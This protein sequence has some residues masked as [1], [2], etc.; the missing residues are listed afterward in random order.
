V[1][2]LALAV[3]HSASGQDWQIQGRLGAGKTHL[4]KGLARRLSDEGL[5]PILVSPPRLDEDTAP[6]ALVRIADTLKQSG[7]CNGQVGTL[8]DLSV[9]WERKLDLTVEVI[10]GASERLVLC[11]DEPQRWSPRAELPEAYSRYAQRHAED[12]L[13]ALFRRASC[14]R[15]Y[16]GDRPSG[17]ATPRL[18][19]LPIDPSVRDAA[20]APGALHQRWDQV[21]VQL[22]N[23]HFNP[24]PLEAR[25]LAVLASASSV[26]DAVA[27]YKQSP[28]SW[29]LGEK[30]GVVLRESPEWRPLRELWA[31]LALVRTPFD[32]ELLNHLADGVNRSE[33]F[34]VFKQGLL[35]WDGDAFQLH[36]VLRLTDDTEGSLVPAPVSLHRSLAN[37]YRQRADAR[38]V[39]PQLTYN[40]EAYHHA[41]RTTDKHLIESIKPFFIEQLHVHGR[42]LSKERKDYEAAAGIFAQAIALDD[43]D[44]YAH[45]YLAYNTDRLAGDATLVEREYRKAIELNPTH[46]WWWSRWINFLITVGRL[47]DARREWS[48]AI[49]ELRATEEWERASVFRELH[50]W[51]ARLLLHRSQLDFAERV[52]TDVPESVRSEHTGFRA[53]E[54]WLVVMREARRA[55]AVFPL[56]IPPS[57]WWRQE[58]HLDFPSALNGRSRLQWNPARVEAIEDGSV[59]LVVGQ[60]PAD[61]G[62][63][64]SYGRIELS[65]E[66][67]NEASLDERAESLRAGRFLELAF[68][69]Q[70]GV[71]RL[72]IHPDRPWVDPELPPLDPPDP[73]RYLKKDDSSA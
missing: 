22:E 23:D 36:D 60:E 51:V 44:D 37:F 20:V 68:Y 53:L 17:S 59:I 9:S 40:I 16:T 66:R 8:T 28:G 43:T 5:I 35:E 62:G 72:R 42:I 50:L 58:P 18:H 56:H 19:Q 41:I 32:E 34:E 61:P 25:L 10:N 65:S 1:E 52:L 14:R 57:D 13:H 12:L 31:K 11:C 48:V 15:V 26:R 55:R 33:E 54:R 7:V 69:G 73:Q 70:D 24:S 63:L 21:R 38:D 47:S 45:H 6:A 39:S 30:L 67:F 3:A 27:F 4:L 64:P 49:D 29:Q 71:L 46:A 2:N